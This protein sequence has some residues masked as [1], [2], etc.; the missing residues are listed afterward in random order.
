MKKVLFFFLFIL[1]SCSASKVIT[2][3]DANINFKAF[4]TYNFYSDIGKGLHELDVKRIVKSLN[5]ELQ[6]KEF[7]MDENPDFYIHIIS[8]ISDVKNYN[9]VGIGIGSGTNNGGFGI[10]GGIPIGVKKRNEEFNIEFVNAQTNEVFWLGMLNSTVKENRKPQ[11]KEH[12]F[13]E[14]IKKILEKYPPN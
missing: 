3:Y 12:H 4:T 2:D 6:Q 11:E 8:K 7:S 13:Q 10:S 9:T 14:I 5:V 1:M